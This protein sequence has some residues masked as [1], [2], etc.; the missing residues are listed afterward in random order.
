MDV[1]PDGRKL[2]S[3]GYDGTVRYWD[4]AFGEQKKLFRQTGYVWAVKF[5]PDGQQAVS[6]GGGRFANG[7]HVPGD[8]F[9]IRIWSLAEEGPARGR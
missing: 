3:C 9:D 7:K 8:D 4:A 6:A 5:S 1:S 2:L